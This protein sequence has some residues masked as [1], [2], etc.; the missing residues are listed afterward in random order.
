MPDF[1]NSVPLSFEHPQT[2]FLLIS[3][4]FSHFCLLLSLVPLSL[5]KPSIACLGLVP[6][7]LAMATLVLLQSSQQPYLAALQNSRD[8]AW[9]YPQQGPES[10]LSLCKQSRYFSRV[11][12]PTVCTT[13]SSSQP[14]SQMALPPC[15]GWK[16]FSS[17]W[18]ARAACPQQ[19]PP[20]PT[21]AHWRAAPISCSWRSACIVLSAE[22]LGKKNKQTNKTLKMQ[23][24]KGSPGHLLEGCASPVPA[25][26]HCR[27]SCCAKFQCLPRALLARTV[28]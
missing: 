15:H 18:G 5:E 25:V 24:N 4:C 26:H 21:L 19:Q 16:V 7:P 2:P 6:R 27:R 12:A 17:F 9:L 22:A 1:P 14:L 23:P 13:S 3:S 28:P 10:F 20:P 11:R 8:L